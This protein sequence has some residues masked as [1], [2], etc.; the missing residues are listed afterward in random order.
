MATISR[1]CNVSLSVPVSQGDIFRHVK[2]SYID[3]EMD[4]N[5]QV[6]E[7]EFP[8]A[9]VISQA[10][11]VISMEKMLTEHKGK[12][13]KFMPSILMCPIYDKENA[14]NGSH[15][16]DAFTE[17]GIEKDNESLFSS[18]E[19]NIVQKDWHYRFHDLTVNRGNENIIENHVIDF[20]NYFT[21]PLSYLVCNKSDRIVHLDDIFAE[22]I[23]LK[24]ATFLTRVAIPD[25]K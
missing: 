4:N 25:D 2:Y 7:Y 10:C 14:K 12:V 22:Q 8:Y 1:G 9:V 6:I 17:L 11:D 13:T 5:V 21:V 20:K 18:K 24:F 15:L 19:Y 3:K 16:V 23:T